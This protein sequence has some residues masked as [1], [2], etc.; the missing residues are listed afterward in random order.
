[1][2]AFSAACEI[3][4][5]TGDTGGAGGTGGG[6]GGTE[7]TGGMGGGGA[8]MGGMGGMGGAGGAAACFAG[9][10]GDYITDQPDQDFCADN[11]SKDFYDKLANCTCDL[12]MNPATESPCDMACAASACKQMP[13]DA[14]CIACLQD[15][16]K[17]CGD[18]FNECANN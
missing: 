3:K 4:T 2:L 1:M 12:D 7:N 16:Q 6:A 8:G 11:P 5:E 17:G 13:A 9:S 15:T 10:C 18:E 14:A